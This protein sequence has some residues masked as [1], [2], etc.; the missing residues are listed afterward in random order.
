MITIKFFI[1]KLKTKYLFFKGGSETEPCIPSNM[2]SARNSLVSHYNLE[3][4]DVVTH[5]GIGNIYTPITHH[6]NKYV[7]PKTIDKHLIEDHDDPNMPKPYHP[8]GK[9]S[10]ISNKS[11][12]LDKKHFISEDPNIK[13][14]FAERKSII[15]RIDEENFLDHYKYYHSHVDKKTFNLMDGS[16]VT[17]IDS[18]DHE[19]PVEVIKEQNTISVYFTNTE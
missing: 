2:E 10:T 7:D 13:V 5:V 6:D 1:K 16:E 15:K 3:Q 11:Y 14:E 19:T 9:T 18:H 17:I 12:F 8:E 4:K